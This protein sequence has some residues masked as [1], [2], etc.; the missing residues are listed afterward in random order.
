MDLGIITPF[1]A[2]RCGIFLVGAEDCTFIKYVNGEE[3]GPGVFYQACQ[4]TFYYGH[5]RVGGGGKEGFCGRRT[6]LRFCRR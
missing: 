4:I 3:V 5:T 2:G 6:R 1:Y